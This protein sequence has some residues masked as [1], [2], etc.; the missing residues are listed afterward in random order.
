MLYWQY[1]QPIDRSKH[2]FS[3]FN[4][5]PQSIPKDKVQENWTA[6]GK[7]TQ[8]K[9]RNRRCVIQ[10]KRTGPQRRKLNLS[11]TDDKKPKYVMFK[12]IKDKLKT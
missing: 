6:H 5:R 3:Q 4:N 8:N 12:V 10:A 1:L 7:T 2:K 9:E 11:D